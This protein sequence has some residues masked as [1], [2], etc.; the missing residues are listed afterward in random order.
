[1]VVIRCV[2]RVPEL[3]ARAFCCRFARTNFCCTQS[4]HY[5]GSQYPVSGL[6]PLGTCPADPCPTQNVGNSTATVLIEIC[7]CF[8]TEKCLLHQQRYS[9]AQRSSEMVLGACKGHLVAPYP[10]PS[11]VTP[12]DSTQSS[13]TSSQ[14]L[15]TSP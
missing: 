7:L 8:R 15:R 1:M 2:Q 10:L 4:G 11:S 14:H 5:P 13:T 9:S 6:V 12:G 3:A